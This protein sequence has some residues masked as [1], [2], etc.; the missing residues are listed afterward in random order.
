MGF[1]ALKD[2][3]YLAFLYYEIERNQ[4]KVITETHFAH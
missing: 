2:L 3:N 4:M 1:F